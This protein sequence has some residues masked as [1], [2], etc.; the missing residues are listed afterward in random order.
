MTTTAQQQQ[1]DYY[2]TFYPR[3]RDEIVFGPPLRL[4][5]HTVYH[6]KD[7]FSNWF[8]RV[9]TKEYFVF[10]RMDGTRSLR[11]I[12]EEYFA[13]FGRRLNDSS[14][15]SL[16]S[17]IEK[18]QMLANTANMAKLEDWKQEANKKKREG[19][20]GLLRRRFALLKPDRFLTQ[21]LPWLAFLFHP[22]FV[23][24]ALLC[25]VTLE[26]FV[27]FH[28]H[29]IL[30]DMIAGYRN[31]WTIVLFLGITWVVAFFHECAHG[32][33]CKR[34]GGA[35]SE[36]GILWRYLSFFPYCK[37]DD[38]LLFHNRWHRVY[39]SLAGV[40]INLL[41]ILPFGVLWLLAPA[42]SLLL[43]V[44]SIMLFSFNISSFTNLIPFV[45]LDGY[46]T[47]NHM[48]NM[49]DLRKESNLYWKRGALKVLLKKGEGN[50]GA[51][52][53]RDRRIYFI[54][55]LLSLTFTALFLIGSLISW[56]FLGR[57]WLGD[58]IT[59]AVLGLM[60]VIFLIRGPGK[61]WFARTF[62]LAERWASLTA[63]LGVARKK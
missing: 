40:Y 4:G 29:N 23:I 11:Q 21:L 25:I 13:E 41:C 18:R 7:R 56:Y 28:A 31:V 48:L 30:Q 57:Y 2:E 51:Y 9:G 61:S 62:R 35:V 44:S 59:W 10:S 34:F 3:L 8:Y 63:R 45:E 53:L 6:L 1:V 17:I 32:L 52:T 38:V 19:G 46:F 22:F 60:I 49:V 27:G 42:H 5:T 54:Y 24:P 26:V 58:T 55:G 39:T 16:F 37:I 47:L 33:A 36:I 50:S 12:G 20:R 15:G 14:W 43:A